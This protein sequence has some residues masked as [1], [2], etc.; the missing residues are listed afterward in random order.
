MCG[1]PVFLRDVGDSP[2]T[3]HI[4]L[5]KP[6]SVLIQGWNLE[7]LA[8]YVHEVIAGSPDG[9][10][11]D[12]T[13]VEFFPKGCPTVREQETMIG[14]GLDLLAIFEK[15]AEDGPRTVTIDVY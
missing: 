1:N 5:A 14:G 6:R 8:I 13:Q 2:I 15:H 10:T 11:A 3:H 4:L 7:L 9:A 12:L